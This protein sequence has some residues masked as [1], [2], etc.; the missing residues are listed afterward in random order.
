MPK[1]ILVDEGAFAFQ[2]LQLGE[3]GMF[4]W[5]AYIEGL[6][7]AIKWAFDGEI[8][9]IRHTLE[10]LLEGQAK[11]HNGDKTISLDPSV[12]GDYDLEA[13]R[14]YHPGGV[15]KIGIQGRPEAE[16]LRDQLRKIPQGTY[17]LKD[18]AIFTGG[19]VKDIL[20]KLKERKLHIRKLDVG[21][22]V[23]RPEIPIRVDAV[24]VYD[25]M[26]VVD[27]NDCRDFLP[28][29]YKGGLVVRYPGQRVRLAYILPMV[30]V[31]NRASIPR[32]QALGFSRRL[33]RLGQTFW[34]NFPHVTLSQ[35]GYEWIAGRFGMTPE[36]SMRDFCARMAKVL[37]FPDR[38][39]HCMGAKGVIWV[40][41]NGTLITTH[42]KTLSKGVTPDHLRK[43]VTEAQRR[44]WDIG[45]CS[46]SPHEPLQRWGMDHGINGPILS[47]NG[48]V[49][50]GCAITNKTVDAPI[51]RGVVRQ[52]ADQKGITIHS[53]RV[54]PEFNGH[55]HQPE[56]MTGIAFGEG[57]IASVS[58]F[59]YR[60]GEPD[61]ELTS[62]IG[63]LLQKAYGNQYRLDVSP[64][65]G[66]IAVHTVDP[67]IAKAQVLVPIGWSLYKRGRRCVMIGD[68]PNDLTHAPALCMVGVVPG[69]EDAMEMADRVARKSATE[70][71]IELIRSIIDS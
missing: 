50:N 30:D 56:H 22:Q 40:D 60:E 24:R 58:I 36:W 49:L 46:D 5:Q 33:W 14:T 63:Q 9:I 51:V 35:T 11:R 71:V 52:W 28:G 67:Q 8:Q 18:D 39:F 54:A 1:F 53:D 32:H 31:S 43:L 64:E 16:S 62:Q 34:S 21:I 38:E 42:E 7:D 61:K 13:S 26:D 41:L 17:T 48:L 68:S 66:F 65:H 2:H 57:R 45:I 44:G 37:D 19:T 29:T 59:A 3:P 70:G 69:R 12:P 23:G 55:G 47:E 25:P 27:L 15:V 6:T 10:E 20:G 4:A